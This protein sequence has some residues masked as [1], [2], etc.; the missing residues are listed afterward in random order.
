MQPVKID[1]YLYR[2]LIFYLR[3]LAG[4]GDDAAKQLLEDLPAIE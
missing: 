2:E 1:F 3:D 4:R